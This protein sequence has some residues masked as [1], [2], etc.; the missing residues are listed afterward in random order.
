VR[1][2][3]NAFGFG[4]HTLGPR[5]R[6]QQQFLVGARLPGRPL[7][8]HPRQRARDGAA[9][10]ER[11]GPGAQAIEGLDAREAHQCMFGTELK[12]A[13]AAQ[14]VV[15][16]APRRRRIDDQQRVTIAAEA[17]R[18]QQRARA[19]VAVALERRDAHEPHVFRR[20]ER[21]QAGAGLG[22]ADHVVVGKRTA[23]VAVGV[24]IDVTDRVARTRGERAIG[25]RRGHRPAH[26]HQLRL[27]QHR[28]DVARG[29]R[30]HRDPA[31][32]LLVLD[33]VGAARAHS[34]HDEVEAIEFGRGNVVVIDRG[35]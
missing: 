23:V 32:D 15:A 7:L 30:H 13:Q 26:T 5:R 29:V 6:T 4:E 21:E 34:L 24:R 1:G 16:T 17:A 33:V 9:V 12:L 31:E 35:S 8:V 2:Q 28:G 10:R 11:L 20:G 19:D 22:R 14:S 3:A 18:H 27:L 25:T